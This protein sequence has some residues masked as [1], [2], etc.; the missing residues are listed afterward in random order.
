MDPR[1]LHYYN[2][3]LTHIRE[4]GGEFA[5]EFPKIA[6]RLGLSGFECADPYVER[7]LEGFAFLAARVQ[8]KIDDEFPAFT[9]HL[10]EMVYPHY[11]APTPSMTVVEL[12]PDPREGKLAEG[13]P[14]PRDTVLR[15]R[16]GPGEQT[17]CQYRTAHDM[18]LWPLRIAEAEYFSHTG[19]VARTDLAALKHSKAG[20]RLRLECTGDLTFDQLAL[21]D[22][23]RFKPVFFLRGADQFPFHLYAR[24]LGGASAVLVQPTRRPAPFIEVLPPSALQPVGFDDAEALLPYAPPSFQGYRNLHEYFAFPERYLFVAV[25]GLGPVLP[26][27]ADG[28]LDL[29]VLLSEPA[30]ELAA[31][32]DADNF[33]LHCTPAINLFPMRFDRI[34]LD[35]RNAEQHVIPDRTRPVDFEVYSIERVTGYGNASADERSFQPF[36]APPSPGLPDD[37]AA[38]YSVHRV[39]RRL[40]GQQRRDGPRSSYIGSEVFINIVDADAAPWSQRLRQLGL[41][42]LCTNRDLPLQLPLGVEDSDFTLEVGAPVQSVRVIAGPTPPRPSHAHG[43]TAWRLISHLALNYLSIAD[44]EGGRGVAALRDLLSLY[45]NLGEPQTRR[46]IEGVTDVASRRVTRRLPGVRPVTY[47]RG[48][49]I[50]VSCDESAF[51]GTGAFLLAAVLE[52]FFARYCSINGF[53]ETVLR[54][55]AGTNMRWPARLGRRPVL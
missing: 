46:Q 39:P 18:V 6:A 5:A 30:P 20:I 32:L 4:V 28:A 47:A 13:Y 21:A 51:E 8:L 26:R 44:S 36:Y 48:L 17:A 55:S 15:G 14:V 9:H 35:D 45:A 31:V 11:L 54:G 1:L 22:P 16:M 50:T 40:S 29:I 53:T 27:I 12:A 38:Y 34:H 37:H 10:L 52:R 24:L 2:R 7:L 42:G 25:A 41:S 3:E 33:A 43:D 19:P 49:E 23:K